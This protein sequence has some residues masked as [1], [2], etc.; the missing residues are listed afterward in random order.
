MTIE[1]FFARNAKRAP[2][3]ARRNNDVFGGD[4]SLVAECDSS[5][6]Q[7]CPLNVR[8]QNYNAC[9][10]S[11]LQEVVAELAPVGSLDAR[12]IPDGRVYPQELSAG[13][14]FVL[15]ECAAQT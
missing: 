9:F 7:I 15:Q 2:P 4:R 5:S 11:S 10:Y 14:G 12:I 6:G 8:L 13:L 3:D 1:L